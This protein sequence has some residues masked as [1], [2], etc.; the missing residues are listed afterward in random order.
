M[1]GRE[2]VHAVITPTKSP[3]EIRYRH[4]FD[5]VDS[6]AR[7]LRQLLHRRAPRPLF[8]ERSDVHFINDLAFQFQAWPIHIRPS[9][10]YWIDNAGGTVRSIR[11]KT[12]RRI[13]IKIRPIVYTEAI[14]RT[15]GNIGNSEKIS[16]LFGK[17][18]VKY[19]LA[20]FRRASF[21]DKVDMFCFRGPNTKVNLLRPD[22]FCPNRI[23]AL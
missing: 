18:W 14:E 5:H 20:I 9:E 13:G 10:F 21:E 16:V 7:Q 4:Y 2:K 11:L 19:S 3:R 15:V 1:R 8:G 23:A 17:Q 6:N 22:Q 12:G